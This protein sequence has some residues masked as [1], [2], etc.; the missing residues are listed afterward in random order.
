MVEDVHKRRTYFL[1]VVIPIVFYHGK[2]PYYFSTDIGDL[3]GE[4]KAWAPIALKPFKLI[5]VNQI[6]D[7][8]IKK[9]EWLGVLE[10]VQKYIGT[11][12]LFYRL[13]NI[14][15][16][17]NQLEIKG[18][19]WYIIS[20]LKYAFSA[21]ALADSQVVQTL[22]LDK[23]SFNTRREM[24]TYAEYL[25]QEA[26][27]EGL[28]K[29]LQKGVQKGIQQGKQLGK[30]EAVQQIAIKLLQEKVDLA[31]I[32]RTT[33]LTFEQIKQLAACGV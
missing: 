6:D 29:G 11:K 12:D 23:L 26:R 10:Y 2:S 15:P 13:I 18:A 31:L 21:G 25:K 22:L 9:H 30:S 7:E 27:Q 3:F 16:L 5:D 1:P 24:M 33:G 20:T 8:E 14:I 19:Q 32:A 17:F 4:H 28:Q